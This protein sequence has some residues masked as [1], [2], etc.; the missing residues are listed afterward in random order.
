[1]FSLS[2]RQELVVSELSLKAIHSEGQRWDKQS[3][4]GGEGAGRV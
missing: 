3:D 1:M 2:L 4:K